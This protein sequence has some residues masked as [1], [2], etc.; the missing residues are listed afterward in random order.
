MVAWEILALMTAFQAL[1][2]CASPD[3]T[4]LGELKRFVGP[5]TFTGYLFRFGSENRGQHSFK[6]LI[7]VAIR[8]PDCT[9]TAIHSAGR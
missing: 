5:A 6:F 2:A 4:S 8:H 7:I 3:S 9:N 1:F